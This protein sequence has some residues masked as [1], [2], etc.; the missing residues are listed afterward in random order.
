LVRRADTTVIGGH[1]RLLVARRLGL[2]TVPVIWLEVSIDQA[3]L[4]GLA[5]NRIGGSW[6]E[7]LL[8]RLLVELGSSPAV[9]LSLSGFGPDEITDL[10]RKLETR[11]GRDRPETFDLEQA[12]EEAPRR[13]RIAYGQLWRLGE[14]RLLCGDA[15]SPADIERLLAGERPVMAFTDPPYNVALGDLGARGRRPKRRHMAN[16]DLDPSAWEAFVRAWGANL[17]GCVDGAIYIAMSAKELPVLCRILLE[18]GAHWSDTIIWNKDRFAPGHSD[19]QRLYEPIWYGWREGASHFWCGDRD[20]VDVWQIARPAV[21]PLHAT[22]KPLAL[23]ERAINNSSRPGD[24]IIDIF[25]G[26]GSTLI[27][28]ERT[29]RRCLGLEIDPVYADIILG[30]WESFAGEKAERIDG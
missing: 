21:S 10:L 25:A 18:Q 4:L 8:G 24:L 2:R 6:D 17:L 5:L 15:T 11:E 12:L 29:G 28:A 7:P 9:D 20:Q 26:S 27:G 13:G 16:D 22:T 1:Q 30:R 3:R 14:H 23:V 19:Y